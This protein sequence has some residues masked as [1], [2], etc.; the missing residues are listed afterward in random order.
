M[1]ENEIADSKPAVDGAT[2]TFP[3]AEGHE[4]ARLAEAPLTVSTP[5]MVTVP[6]A[7]SS[8]NLLAPRPS[9]CIAAPLDLLPVVGERQGDRAR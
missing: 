8:V 9:C 4:T 6:D 5:G 3:Y 7:P 2:R 1:R